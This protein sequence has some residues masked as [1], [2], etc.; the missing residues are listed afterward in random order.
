MTIS[1][2]PDYPLSLHGNLKKYLVYIQSIWVYTPTIVLQVLHITATQILRPGRS[3]SPRGSR[4]GDLCRA[5]EGVEGLDL[6]SEG[7]WRCRFMLGYSAIVPKHEPSSNFRRLVAAELA[8]GIV[9]GPKVCVSDEDRPLP[10]PKK[11]KSVFQI[12]QPSN[13]K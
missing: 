1:L 8:P 3:G 10:P 9:H 5:S 7:I 13:S 2:K 4:F 6:E 11:N 12:F